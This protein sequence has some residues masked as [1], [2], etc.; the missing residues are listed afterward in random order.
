ML[1]VPPLA[2][3]L[4]IRS[5]SPLTLAP[6]S[7]MTSPPDAPTF[8]SHMP[9]PHA[10]SPPVGDSLPHGGCLALAALNST[11][12]S[13]DNR[14]RDLPAT[15]GYACRYVSRP[16]NAFPAQITQHRVATPTIYTPPRVQG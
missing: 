13:P 3:L 11:T 9:Y 10:L 7:S 8:L 1:N 16:S 14:V 15:A 4:Y 5:T 12:L 2:A 6:S